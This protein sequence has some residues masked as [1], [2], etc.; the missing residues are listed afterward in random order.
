[1]IFPRNTR[2]STYNIDVVEVEF[3]NTIMIYSPSKNLRNFLVSI[4]L[5]FVK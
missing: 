3:F 1:M 2:G 4:W 5:L